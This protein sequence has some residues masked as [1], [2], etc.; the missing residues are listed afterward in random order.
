[1][2]SCVFFYAPRP[3]WFALNNLLPGAHQ[4]QTLLNIAIHA[5]FCQGS[6]HAGAGRTTRDSFHCQVFY[7]TSGD[8]SAFILHVCAPVSGE[9]HQNKLLH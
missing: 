4:R 1:M 5:R 7:F 8:A 9:W 3:P 2:D 6:K